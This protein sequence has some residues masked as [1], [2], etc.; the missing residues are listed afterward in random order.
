MEGPGASSAGARSAVP[1]GA[2]LAPLSTETDDAGRT[3]PLADE[4]QARQ[5]QQA[6]KQAW[7][8]ERV[9]GQ[10]E[11]ADAR[12]RRQLAEQT[13]RQRMQ[14]WRQASP[15][16]MLEEHIDPE[17]NTVLYDSGIGWQSESPVHVWMDV[18]M[19]P[20]PRFASEE[21]PWLGLS[22]VLPDAGDF[23]FTS[24]K[25]VAD[26]ASH[27]LSGL[28]VDEN[29]P[30]AL[31]Q[32]SVSIL[33]ATDIRF[34]Q[35]FVRAKKP[36]LRY[37]GDSG[38]RSIRVSAEEIRALR[39]VMDAWAFLYHA[40]PADQALAGGGAAS[41][42]A[43][44]SLSW[45]GLRLPRRSDED[46]RMP[47]GGDEARRIYLSVPPDGAYRRSQATEGSSG[48]GLLNTA[49]TLYILNTLLDGDR[50]Q[51]VTGA[52]V[53]R[54]QGGAGPRTATGRRDGGITGAGTVEGRAVGR[55]AA[56]SPSAP[57]TGARR[58]AASGA[59]H[60]SPGTVGRHRLSPLGRAAVRGGS[61]RDSKASRSGVLGSSGS[62]KFRS[63]ASGGS[64]RSTARSS[65]SGASR[66]KRR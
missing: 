39:Q 33:D 10:V 63:R 43:A 8:Q 5:R 49:A 4:Q 50:R 48:S 38:Q 51:P 12:A 15:L 52:R 2:G 54:D 30:P 56:S 62:G 11:A 13:G 47:A 53:R 65:G 26:R 17:E 64:A 7:Q 42:Q 40:V 35:R 29:S 16:A 58:G 66:G 14:A 60:A 19:Y 55:Q 21:S 32:A 1:A 28:V 6:R 59:E 9:R 25:L 37:S 61:R 24:V 46:E 23:R 3:E 20:K 34:M 27:Q 18:T 57:T 45:S 22:I 44:D 41:A 36:V 31:R